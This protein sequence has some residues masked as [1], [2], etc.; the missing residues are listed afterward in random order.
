MASRSTI[1]IHLIVKAKGVRT[2]RSPYSI[3]GAQEGSSCPVE[4]LLSGY[5][6]T[7]IMLRLSSIKQGGRA[8]GGH[9]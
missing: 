3:P 8:C 7:D 1:G 2:S 9:I 6:N 4:K 5:H